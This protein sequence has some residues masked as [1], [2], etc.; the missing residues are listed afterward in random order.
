MSS[1]TWTPKEV[2]SSAT[3]L[4]FSLWRAVEG[5]HVAATLRL[6]DGLDEQHVLEELLEQHKPAVPP[7]ARG[8]HYLLFTPFRYPSP[9]GSRFRGPTDPGVFYGAD[10]RRT[11]C[12]EV[13]YWRWRFLQDSAGLRALGRLGPVPHTLF[14][15][16]VEGAGIDLRRPPLLRDCALWTDPFDYS[17]TQ[18]LG[19]L[20]RGVALGIVRYE[21]VRDPQAGGCAAI[22]RPDTFRSGRLNVRET[23][24]LTVT[25]TAASWQSERAS[26]EFQTSHAHWAAPS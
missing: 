22:L 13:A 20:A 6:V 23:W 26:F 18:A 7:E 10:L 15:T 14:R 16:D 24:F 8:L 4:R 11:A 12:A 19:R 21:S 2:A 9:S 25:H 3:P 17:H 1:I 5:Q